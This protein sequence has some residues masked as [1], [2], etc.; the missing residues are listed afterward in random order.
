[1]KETETQLVKSCLELLAYK[2]IFAYRM[3]S[4]A[5]KTEAGGFYRMSVIGA[6]DIVAVVNGV[7]VG[8]EAKIGKNKQSIAQVEFQQGLEKAGGRYLLIR[9]VDELVDELE[10]LN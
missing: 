3:N 2:K 7:Y 5:F 4:G 6:P 9:S 10:K 8:I 1:M